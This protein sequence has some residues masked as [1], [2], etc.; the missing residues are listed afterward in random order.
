[1]PYSTSVTSRIVIA[2]RMLMSRRDNLEELFH[3]V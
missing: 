3:F 1:M 2:T